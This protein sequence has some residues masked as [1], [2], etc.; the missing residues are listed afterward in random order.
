MTANVPHKQLVGSSVLSGR[1]DPKV[2]GRLPVRNM[3]IGVDGMMLLSGYG[4]NAIAPGSSLVTAGALSNDSTG[5][6]LTS[7]ASADDVAALASPSEVKLGGNRFALQCSIDLVTDSAANDDCAIFLGF[8][9]P[10]GKADPLQDLANNDVGLLID[11]TA[12]IGGSFGLLKKSSAATLHFSSIADD[13]SASQVDS[14]SLGTL[15][16][17]AV[18]IKMVA[19]GRGK[20][21]VSF[22]GGA[23]VEFDYPAVEKGHL[24]LAVKNEGTDASA[25]GLGPRIAFGVAE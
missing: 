15:S 25:L 20:I 22:D 6:V 23:D 21:K 3:L 19:D 24:I 12:D 18:S 5:H 17:T 7:G 13:A 14:A 4:N 10:E 11:S 16:T 8:V 1:L 2:W 9:P